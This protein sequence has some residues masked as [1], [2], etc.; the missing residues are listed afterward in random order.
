MTGLQYFPRFSGFS[1]RGRQPNCATFCMNRLK[2]LGPVGFRQSKT[3]LFD[4]TL[5]RLEFS[6]PSYRQLSRLYSFRARPEGGWCEGVLL[7]SRRNWLAA[8][9][10][11][12]SRFL[13][14]DR[15]D[16]PS[17]QR[18]S[19]FGLSRKP[20]KKATIVELHS[21]ESPPSYS[22]RSRCWQHGIDTARCCRRAIHDTRCWRPEL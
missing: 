9:L 21:A 15:L 12:A 16:E 13:R 17:S 20:P 19:G 4:W 14:E 2:V 5:F 6:G 7:Y 10:L 18:V 11:C 3:A 1:K 8:K 22:R